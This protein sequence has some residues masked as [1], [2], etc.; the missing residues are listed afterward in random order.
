MAMNPIGFEATLNHVANITKNKAIVGWYEGAT[1]PDGTK[2]SDVAMMNEYGTRT[3]VARPFI[4]PAI[5]SNGDEW[6]DMMLRENIGGDA[7]EKIALKAEGDIMDSI[8]NGDHKKLS[9]ITLAL[10]K[11]R[12]NGEKITGKSVG[13]AANAIKN[14]TAVFSTNTQPLSDTG[15]MIATLTSTV[16]HND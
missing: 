3:S 9:P 7:L 16:I 14:G 1:Y 11:M 12:E 10:R 5:M 15:R 6:K 4:R 8:V 13:I 2:V